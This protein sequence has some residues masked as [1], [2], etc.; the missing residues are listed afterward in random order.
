M[1]S[2]SR[3]HAPQP[4]CSDHQAALEH[5]FDGE[6]G[7]IADDALD[8][9]VDGC[10]DCA[11]Y[12]RDLRHVRGLLQCLPV[13]AFPRDALAEVLSQTV[14]QPAV[15]SPFTILRRQAVNLALAAVLTLA[16]VGAWYATNGGAMT[17]DPSEAELARMERDLNEIMYRLGSTLRETEHVAIR[18][19]LI[20]EA[21][22]P[23]RISPFARPSK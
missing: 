4:T 2:D 8:R 19:V 23:L 17:D 15:S 13:K 5:R 21:S 10:P 6:P 20:E 16:A 22:P 11:D 1:I 12:V 7:S 9:H 18:E 3:G 14:D